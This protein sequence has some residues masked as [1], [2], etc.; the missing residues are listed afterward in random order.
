MNVY[1]VYLR[2][3]RWTMVR[4]EAADQTAARSAA[5]ALLEEYN[6]PGG[7]VAIEESSSTGTVVGEVDEVSEAEAWL[8]RWGEIQYRW[9]GERL[10]LIGALGS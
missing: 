2:E 1:E 5:S 10:Q 9:D 6:T 8:P 4:V 3:E 7:M